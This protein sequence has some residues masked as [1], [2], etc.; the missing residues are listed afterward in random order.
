MQGVEGIPTTG[1]QVLDYVIASAVV[2]IG[3]GRVFSQLQEWG[4]FP[5]WNGNGKKAGDLTVE[6]FEG[7]VRHAIRG[8]LQPITTAQSETNRRLEK[9]NE[10]LIRIATILEQQSK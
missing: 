5:R 10:T 9:A 2:L 4:F 8:E 7:K 1:H 3:T 6:S